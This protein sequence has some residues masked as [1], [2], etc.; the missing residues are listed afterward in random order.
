MS[1]PASNSNITI[2]LGIE[3]LKTQKRK[4]KNRYTKK[5]SR[6]VSKIGAI[7]FQHSMTKTKENESKEKKMK[8]SAQG[9]MLLH[10]PKSMQISN[11]LSL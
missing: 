8:R 9:S 6:D 4:K 10:Y 1:T 3:P 2:A 11:W 5:N 7:S